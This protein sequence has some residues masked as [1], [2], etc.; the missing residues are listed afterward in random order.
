M[1]RV[2]AVSPEVTRGGDDATKGGGGGKPAAWEKTG[3]STGKAAAWGRYRRV[4][5]DRGVAGVAVTGD[6]GGAP[7]LRRD[8]NEGD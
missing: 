6:G 5:G 2:A 4:W 7:R 1:P 3:A 8:Q